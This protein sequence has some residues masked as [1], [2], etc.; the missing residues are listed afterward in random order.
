[1]DISSLANSVSESGA[2][3]SVGEEVGKIVKT[4][5]GQVTGST[6]SDPV[7]GKVSDKDLESLKQKDYEFSKKAEA[8]LQAKIQSMYAQY[9]ARSKQEVQRLAEQHKVEEEQEDKLEKLNETRVR[10][11]FINPAIEQTRPENKNYGAE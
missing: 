7:T 2:S 10:Q 3:T 11:N 9:A 8:E 1:M 6:I 4:I 5:V